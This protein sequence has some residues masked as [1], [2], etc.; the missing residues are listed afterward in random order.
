MLV[1]GV[2]ARETPGSGNMDG[3]SPGITGWMTGEICGNTLG[4]DATGAAGL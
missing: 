3:D 2:D 4:G 1:G